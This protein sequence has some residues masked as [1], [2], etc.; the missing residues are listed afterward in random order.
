MNPAPS[1]PESTIARARRAARYSAVRLLLA[2]VLLFAVT[3][4]VEDLPNGDLIEAV[5]VTAVMVAAVRA[6]GGQR[7]THLIAMALIIPALASKWINHLQPGLMPP[8]VPILAAIMFFA[9][10]IAHLI[11]FIVRSP[12]VDTNVVCAGV[13]G[14]LLLGWLWVP[15][16]LLVARLNPAAFTLPSAAGSGAI[17]SAFDAFYFSFIT[18]GTI[19]YGDI[20]PASKVA[21]TLAAAQGITGLFYMAVLISRLVSMHSSSKSADGIDDEAES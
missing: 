19:G 13:A 21:R 15:A 10:V 7:Q 8:A 12:R 2:L 3:P 9:F 17:F 16:Y 20:T 6:L 1:S 5:L 14:F 18:L 4:F 11:R